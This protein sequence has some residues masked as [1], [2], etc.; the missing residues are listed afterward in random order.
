VISSTVPT[1][2][3]SA[4]AVDRDYYPYVGSAGIA[5]MYIRLYSQAAAIGLPPEK[6]EW[7]SSQILAHL[8]AGWKHVYQPQ[9][10]HV[11]PLN[12]VVGPAAVEI[13]RQILT[14]PTEAEEQ[15]KMRQERW[16]TALGTLSQAIEVAK[17]DKQGNREAGNAEVL[18]GRAG[19]F[20][21]LIGLHRLLHEGRVHDE[22]K[23]SLQ[24][25]VN[26]EAMKQIASAIIKAGRNGR[27]LLKR[28][29]FSGQMYGLELIWQWHGKIYIGAIHGIAG[30]I[31]ILLQCP[32]GVLS[33]EE[34]QSVLNTARSLLDMATQL[35][36]HLPSSIPR[37]PRSKV[38]LV[39]LCHGAP[40]L[41]L[42]G[43]ALRDHHR[44]VLAAEL[45]AALPKSCEAVWREGILIKGI[46]ICHGVSGNAWTILLY[47]LSNN[48]IGRDE[49]ELLGKALSM[50]VHSTRL[51]PLVPNEQSPADEKYRM[52]DCP[53][54]LFEGLAGAVCAWSDAATFIHNYLNRLTD[55]SSAPQV[56]LFGMPGLGCA[57]GGYLL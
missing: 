27:K 55:S 47:A 50:L 15:P 26:I 46:S 20:W 12:S 56:P 5:M 4:E 38:E 32:P 35:E 29:A 33:E 10:S 30:I 21:L 45:D 13:E 53:Y 2:T 39:Q 43:A 28:D 41:L 40:G 23:E 8:P 19:L 1:S 44:G 18:N 14:P 17:S 37:D 36:G 49:V 11:S 42:L 16:K 24:K 22:K 52:P 7:I 9:A 31:T 25:V 57:A 54:S 34:L 48:V 3:L 51:P 6:V